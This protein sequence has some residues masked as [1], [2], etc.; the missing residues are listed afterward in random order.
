MKRPLN[1]A[2][3]DTFSIYAAKRSQNFTIVIA[4]ACNSAVFCVSFVN[5][6]TFM[7]RCVKLNANAVECALSSDVQTKTQF[8]IVSITRD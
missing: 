6:E 5:L 8:S 4:L 7:L 2:F 3:I 1:G